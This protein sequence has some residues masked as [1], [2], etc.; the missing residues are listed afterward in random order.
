MESVVVSIL[1]VV[2]PTVMSVEVQFESVLFVK[3][4]GQ[5]H[6]VTLCAD[7]THFTPPAQEVR[8]GSIHFP[9]D[10]HWCA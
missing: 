3:V 4:A 7:T 10:P 2:V 6:I 9:D 8:Q 5:V 1:C